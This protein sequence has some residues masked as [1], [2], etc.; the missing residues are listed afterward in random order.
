VPNRSGHCL[1]A[2]LAAATLLPCSFTHAQVPNAVERQ[3]DSIATATR[4][5]VVRAL[6]VGIDS[7][8]AVSKLDGAVADA[9][10][11]AGTLQ[12][13]GV[14]DVTIMLNENATRAA[15]VDALE[16]L[17]G[18]ASKDDLIIVTFAG[19]GAQEKTTVSRAEPDGWDEFF[20]L[21]GFDTSGP[22]TA[23]RLLDDEIFS[24]IGRVA[25]TGAHTIFLADV[26]FGGGLS[27]AVDP[28]AARLAVRG[29]KR[30]DRPEM[31]GPNSYYINPR[32]DQLP[33]LANIPP[34]DDATQTFPSLT[35]L[36]AVDDRHE[37]PE[38]RISGEATP[39]GAASYVLARALE[40]RADAEGDQDGATTRRELIAFVRRHVRVLSG[41]RQSPV[42]E[43]RAPGSGQPVLF[44]HQ[45]PAVAAVS[46]VPKP[47]S[48]APKVAAAL[49]ATSS[50]AWTDGGLLWDARTGDVLNASGDVV[51]YGV[52]QTALPAVV[53]R[54]RAFQQ[55]VQLATGRSLDMSISPGDKAFVDGERFE[56]SIDGLYGRYLVLVNLTGDGTLQYLFP[57]GNA[58]NLIDK[59]QLT[60]PLRS[61]APFGTDTLIAI[62]T[63][64]RQAALELDLKL[65]NA[66]RSSSALVE[67]LSRHL[68]YTD[69]LAIG[70]YSTR[71]K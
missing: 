30:V 54:D 2:L 34:S 49:A 59:E 10:D 27:K 6:V 13:A 52:S 56:A 67:L 64:T 70:T 35:F 41:D 8:R 68:D 16:G 46:P 21:W 39:R 19:H 37:A 69:R 57:E 20:V 71:P 11:L 14:T 44:R 25:A 43:P 29:L 4:G 1:V 58:D 18:R 40:G 22:A 65:L 12:R 23:E 48:P 61:E 45:G 33:R 38:V 55:L 28:R 60:I 62:A 9:R 5:G 7:Y 17:A 66:K 24:W 3:A 50:K 15:L 51:A 26:C 53:E 47:G 42:G 63:R 31:T 36:A 32:E